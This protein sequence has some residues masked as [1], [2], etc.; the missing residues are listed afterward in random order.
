MRG[1][2]QDFD[3]CLRGQM[4]GRGQG[5]LTAVGVVRWNEGAG[6]FDSYLSGQMVG[7]GRGL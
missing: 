2:G 3:S 1:R 7:R 4:E 6:D 5:I